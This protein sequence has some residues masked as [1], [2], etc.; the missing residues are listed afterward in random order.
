MTF[1]EVKTRLDAGESES[2]DEVK[3]MIRTLA[4]YGK[5]SPVYLSIA[6]HNS[7]RLYKGKRWSLWAEQTYKLCDEKDAMHRANVGEMLRALQKTDPVR[8]G[9]FMDI[10]ISLLMLWVK[11]F[12]EGKRLV[13]SGK[14]DRSFI[15]LTNFL[16]TH[17]EAFTW[18]REK[19]DQEIKLF[20]NPEAKYVQEELALTFD[21]VGDRIDEK[22]L[23]KITQRDD[24]DGYHAI[25]MANNGAKLCTNAVNVIVKDHANLP[26][27]V[28]EDLDSGLEEAHRKLRAILL[29]RQHETEA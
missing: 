15:P 5:S 1:E 24:F 19:L 20:L 26:V 10:G 2:L 22:E 11:L 21:A 13:K 16:K 3:E 14:I 23:S 27:D 25:I 29:L 28:L 8:H 17:P 9:R 18:K 6:L 4:E 7:Q 12:N